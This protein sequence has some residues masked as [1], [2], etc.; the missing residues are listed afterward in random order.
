M[1]QT[2]SAVRSVSN[3]GCVVAVFQGYNRLWG[4]R[5]EWRYELENGHTCGKCCLPLPDIV[6]TE[7]MMLLLLWL[8][9]QDQSQQSNSS[10]DWHRFLTIK[11]ENVGLEEGGVG[12][13]K[14]RHDQDISV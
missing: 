11:G 13:V 5:E 1:L 4:K 14:G 9:S 10:T 8:L 3:E 6:D 7:P 2:P 12:A